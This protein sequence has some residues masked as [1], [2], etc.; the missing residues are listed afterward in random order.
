MLRGLGLSHAPNR[1]PVV[2]VVVVG[3]QT[4]IV[5]VQVVRVVSIVGCRRPPVPVRAAVVERGI[6][7]VA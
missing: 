3:I 1:V 7:V 4:T 6:V 2:L 5:V